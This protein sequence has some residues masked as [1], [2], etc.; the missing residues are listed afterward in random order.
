MYNNYYV[1]GKKF[2]YFTDLLRGSSFW[3]IYYWRFNWSYS[4]TQTRKMIIYI[5][6]KLPPLS[7]SQAMETASKYIN[8]KWDTLTWLENASANYT[9]SL[10]VQRDTINSS[11]LRKKRRINQRSTNNGTGCVRVN[12][13]LRNARE[14]RRRNRSQRSRPNPPYIPGVI[15]SLLKRTPGSGSIRRRGTVSR[16]NSDAL[17]WRINSSDDRDGGYASKLIWFIADYGLERH[18]KNSNF[19][20]QSHR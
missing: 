16:A 1:S 2:E 17:R 20:T 5:P 12:S 6:T 10:A 11:S 8:R 9:G 3:I 4:H 13:G 14:H 7:P 15:L 19:V 18:E